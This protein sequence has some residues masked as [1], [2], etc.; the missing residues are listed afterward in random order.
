MGRISWYCYRC[1]R[2]HDSIDDCP[3]ERADMW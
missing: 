3:Y 2:Y 1:G